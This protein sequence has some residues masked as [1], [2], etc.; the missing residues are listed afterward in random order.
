[1]VKNFTLLILIVL[2]L[3]SLETVYAQQPAQQDSLAYWVRTKDGNE[4][5]GF[6]EVRNSQELTLRTK[7][8]G[9]VT[10]PLSEIRNIK[11]INPAEVDRPFA[12]TPYAYFTRYYLTSSAITLRKG[13]GYYHNSLFIYNR[14]EYGL[15]DW[16]TIG[17]ET[18][19]LDGNGQFTAGLTNRFQF[20]LGGE[21]FR[22]GAKGTIGVATDEGNA[23]GQIMGLATIGPVDRNVTVGV[24]YTFIQGVSTNSPT[25]QIAG[26]FRVGRKGAVLFDIHLIETGLESLDYYMLGGRHL[27]RRVGL[28][29]AIAVLN[30]DDFNGYAI[31]IPWLGL[32]IP[33]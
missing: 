14:A 30:T 5:K 17:I 6:L 1:M 19:I 12:A 8:L 9:L 15:T 10:I 23:T 31:P 7:N 3:G 11:E 2:S 13:E 32:T 21:N 28:D 33:F 26:D 27:F 24:G 18:G 20:P 4:Y 22:L 29:Y 16:W 25:F